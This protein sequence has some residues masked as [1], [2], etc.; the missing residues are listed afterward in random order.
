MENRPDVLV[1]EQSLAIRI[2]LDQKFG[3]ATLRLTKKVAIL[4]GIKA[5]PARSGSNQQYC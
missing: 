5:A 3:R 2:D 1:I 4:I